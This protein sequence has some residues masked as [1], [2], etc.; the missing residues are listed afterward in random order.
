MALGTFAVGTESFMVAGLLPGMAADLSVSIASAGQL[1]TAFAF[2]YALSAPILAVVT[3]NISRRTLLIF[4][5]GFFALGN[6]MAWAAR[7]YWQLM[8]ARVLLAFAAGLYVPGA[9]ALASAVVTP[10]RRGMA[11]AIV[12]G[13]LSLAIAFGVPLGAM[14]GDSLGWRST[15]GVVALLSGVAATALILFLPKSLG[16]GLRVATIEDRVKTALQPKIL[17]RLLVTSMWAMASYTTYTYLSLFVSTATQLHGAQ[18][19]YILFTWGASA[20]LGLLISGKVIEKLGPRA[21]IAPALITSTLAF[22]LMSTSAHL[23]SRTWEIVPALVAVIAWGI[24]H[25]AFYPAQ[26]TTLVSLAG[27]KSAPVVLSLNASFMY[28]GFSLGAGAGSLTVA[29]SSPANLGYVSAL[30]MTV[31]LL[32]TFTGSKRTS[33]EKNAAMG[34]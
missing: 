32:L 18:I 4:A 5:M 2:A 34:I 30:C 1:V 23:L 22:I 28:L 26:Q 16:Q 21:V 12:N 9:N 3:G 17:L 13:G 6:A 25:W 31:A 14:L 15:F 19:G 8:A 11:I 33:R 10:E 27:I 24:A 29:Y 20:V 7:D